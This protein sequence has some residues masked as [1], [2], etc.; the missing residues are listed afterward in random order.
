M[1]TLIDY[2]LSLFRDEAAAQSFVSGPG[3]AMTN[4]GLINVLPDE[5]ASAAASALPGLPLPE[6]DPIGG[7]QQAVANQYGFAPPWESGYGGDNGYGGYDPGYGGCD[8]GSGG[9]G[10]DSGYGG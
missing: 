4:A 8:P 7:L 2:L 9:Y 10:G 3:Q 6:G 1:N 5:L